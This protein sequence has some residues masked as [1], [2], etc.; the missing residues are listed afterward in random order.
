[1][2]IIKLPKVRGVN[3][4][5]NYGSIRLGWFQVEFPFLLVLFLPGLMVVYFG[6]TSM[7]E[8]LVLALFF[9]TVMFML[10]GSLA[11]TSAISVN[12][13]VF[14]V[15]FLIFI[16]M[17]FGVVSATVWHHVDYA[18]FVFSLLL[19]FWVL[20][21]AP[22]FYND[23]L[24][25]GQVRFSRI[26]HVFFWLTSV[27]GC[28]AGGAFLMGINPYK[29]VVVFNEPSHFAL[30]YLPF[31]FYVSCSSRRWGGIGCFL[32]ALFIALSIQNLTLLV[33]VILL[34]FPV[35]GVW[36][37]LLVVAMMVPIS[38]FL[39]AGISEYG[40]YYFD[41]LNFSSN[42]ENFS[43]M[44]Y[45]SGAERAYLAIVDS[46]G[47]GLGFQQL[48]VVG[49][50]GE[51]MKEIVAALGLTL[52][53]NDG[54]FLGAKLVAEFGILGVAFLVLYVFMAFQLFL[55]LRS[56]CFVG[57]IDLF[58]VCVFLAFSV[59]LFVRGAGY[60]TPSAF[61]FIVSVYFLFV[62]APVG[63][64]KKILEPEGCA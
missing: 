48:G 26:C 20:M 61:M 57:R 3:S 56:N 40:G 24:A 15:A 9:Y 37:V 1:M 42:T 18:R 64:S 38:I 27:M 12:Y 39:L 22:V 11:L 47:L 36:R 7:R 60:F 46:F 34:L 14:V 16:M 54:G 35:Y 45:M 13:L 51:V 49:P 28:V 59:E 53:H 8:G 43:A 31:L 55:K 33:G 52:N 58:F 21:I 50:Q 5:S 6:A 41:R 4:I 19:F 32:I 29:K 25:V 62:M 44:V 30:L 17:H 23:L 2:F 63:R 10:R